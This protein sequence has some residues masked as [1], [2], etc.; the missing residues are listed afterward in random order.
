MIFGSYS[1]WRTR[2]RKKKRLCRSSTGKSRRELGTEDPP[3][4]VGAAYEIERNNGADCQPPKENEQWTAPARHQIAR[5][6]NGAY[7]K[8]KII[9]FAGLAYSVKAI[10][11]KF[12]DLR[13]SGSSNYVDESLVAH[14]QKAESSVML[15]SMAQNTMNNLTVNR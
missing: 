14:Q 5:Y 12:S 11:V 6:Q 13:L 1:R 4:E 8:D 2:C 3:E 7:W 10:C 15:A 9:E